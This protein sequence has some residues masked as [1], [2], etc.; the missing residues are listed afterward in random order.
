[1]ATGPCSSVCT[2]ADL[3]LLYL[4]T[5][6]HTHTHTHTQDAGYLEELDQLLDN[7]GSFSPVRASVPRG[8]E[9]TSADI[10][11]AAAQTPSVV[12]VRVQGPGV[13]DGDQAAA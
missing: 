4:P 2:P 1:M 11:A 12:Q 8:G 10:G 13:R 5:H 6:T 7:V 3:L 9:C